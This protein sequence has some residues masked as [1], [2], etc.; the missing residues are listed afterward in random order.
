[1]LSL[2]ERVSAKIAMATVLLSMFSGGSDS[3]VLNVACCRPNKGTPQHN[4]N[5][6]MRFKPDR[7]LEDFLQFPAERVARGA[8]LICGKL[9]YR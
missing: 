2:A 5:A 6:Q 9:L 8:A 3:L 1:M 4:Q 7:W